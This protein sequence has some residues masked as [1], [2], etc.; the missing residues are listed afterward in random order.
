MV[1]LQITACH[2][3]TSCKEIWKL[4][5][6]EEMWFSSSCCK[7][8]TC[9]QLNLL[10][11]FQVSPKNGQTKF[12]IMSDLTICRAA[13]TTSKRTNH[14]QWVLT[15]C[16]QS[17]WAFLKIATWSTKNTGTIRKARSQ[18]ETHEA[19][20]IIWLHTTMFIPAIILKHS[21]SFN[22]SNVGVIWPLRHWGWIFIKQDRIL[23]PF[24]IIYTSQSLRSCTL[25]NH[26]Q[27]TPD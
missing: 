26:H 1:I 17:C 11:L 10:R 9:L 20:L 14:S 24:V 15:A 5:P 13:F 7:V 27:S 4:I 16:G 23:Q 6:P 22:L 3:E 2:W 19:T 8:K 12:G 18:S 21:L 25:G